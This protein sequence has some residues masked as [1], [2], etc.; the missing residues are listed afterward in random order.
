MPGRRSSRCK[1]RAI[2]TIVMPTETAV[3]PTPKCGGS[4]RIRVDAILPAAGGPPLGQLDESWLPRLAARVQ[5]SGIRKPLVVEPSPTDPGRFEIVEG[6]HRWR[7]A[8]TAGLEEVPCIVDEALG[9]ERRRLLAQAETLR[10]TDLDAV[11][12]ASVLVKFMEALR[13]DASEAGALIGRSYKEARRLL[14]LHGAIYPIKAAVVAKRVDARA[15]LELVRIYNRLVRG[16][17]EGCK[18]A[19]RAHIELLIE[20]VVDEQWSVRTLE[21]YAQG[22]AKGRAL[23]PGKEPGAMAAVRPPFHETR[24]ELLIDMSRLERGEIEPEDRSRLIALLEDLLRR[25]GGA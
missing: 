21:I 5:R 17:G 23:G 8:Q 11:Q 20:R 18:Q 10:R 24:G 19:S 14:Q 2:E 4:V 1:A 25:M 3:M 12:E 15:A 6:E 7:A 16:G 13:L 9:E 22:L